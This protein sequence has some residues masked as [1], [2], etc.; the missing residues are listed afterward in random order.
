MKRSSR[1]AGEETPLSKE[2]YDCMHERVQQTVSS[3]VAP[4]E[5]DDIRALVPAEMNEL[6]R[7]GLFLLK[8]EEK[9]GET[10]DETG[11]L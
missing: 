5:Y 1:R 9:K 10:A 3:R 2:A 4:Q 7:Q 6:Q 8:K 11:K